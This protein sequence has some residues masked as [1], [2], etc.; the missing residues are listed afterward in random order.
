MRIVV[1]ILVFCL[2]ICF[3]ELGHFILA[4]INKIAVDEFCIGMGPKL[5]GIKKG[6]TLYSIRL[7]PI[8]GACMM[9]GE[10]SGEQDGE[11]DESAFYSKSVWARISV[12]IAGPLFN[13]ILAF[14]CAA[15]IIGTVGYTSSEILAVS[16]GSPAM[17]AGLEAGDLITKVDRTNVHTFSDF[18]LYVMLNEDK[19]CTVT[20]ERDGVKYQTEVTPRLDDDGVYRIGI[21]GGATVTPGLGG[22]LVHSV[23]EVGSNINS[24]I[25]SLLML[26]RGQA[27]FSDLSGPVG[28]FQIIGESYES[29]AEYGI[30]SVV[31]TMLDL[32]LLL[33]A[34]LGVMNLLPIP[35]LDGG[36]LLFFLI[37]LV[38]GKP[39]PPDKEGIVD[40]IGF[41]ILMVIMVIVLFNDLWRIFG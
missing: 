25:K 1:A 23:Y 8:G 6:E 13:F 33:S 36:K 16:E 4:K 3:H 27:S 40:T 39:V 18:R 34:N 15:I 5:F 2:I 22:T 29:A 10:D 41:V 24:V 30:G 7:L 31:L 37:E 35:A 17:E 21:T 11:P 9:R 32:I 28:I 38:R 20:Y 26:I 19:A 12:V 14:F